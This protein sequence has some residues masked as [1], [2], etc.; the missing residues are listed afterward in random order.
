LSAREL[1]AA[2]GREHAVHVALKPGPLADSFL[3]EARRLQGFR[4]D[5]KVDVSDR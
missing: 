5:A 1:G 4:A 3:V 2:L